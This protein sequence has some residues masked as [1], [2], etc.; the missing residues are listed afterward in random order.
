MLFKLKG[1]WQYL[2]NICNLSQDVKD[3]YLRNTK[4]TDGYNEPDE[5]NNAVERSELRQ[6]FNITT[7]KINSFHEDEDPVPG[8]DKHINEL[9]KDFKMLSNFLLQSLAVSLGK[10]K[11]RCTCTAANLHLKVKKMSFFISTIL[12]EELMFMKYIRKSYEICL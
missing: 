8:F 11:E 3:Q 10:Y 2:D 9:A 5:D 1:A 12:K 7:L 6:A 4:K